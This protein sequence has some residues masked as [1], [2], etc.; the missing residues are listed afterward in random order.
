MNRDTYNSSVVDEVVE[1][2]VP[3]DRLEILRG[4]SDTLKVADVELDNVQ[5]SIRCLP[6]VL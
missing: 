6:Q 2:A 5:R 3:E 1:A 4:R